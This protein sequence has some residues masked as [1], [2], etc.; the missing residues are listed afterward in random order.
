MGISAG[1]AV[2]G[3]VMMPSRVNRESPERQSRV[4]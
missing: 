1:K 2:A 4:L 3:S